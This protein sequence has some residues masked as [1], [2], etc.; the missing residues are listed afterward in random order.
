[1][2][3][4]FQNEGQHQKPTLGPAKRKILATILG[5][6]KTIWV[7]TQSNPESAIE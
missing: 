4:A 6:R 7:K 1:L 3:T 5:V 2:R